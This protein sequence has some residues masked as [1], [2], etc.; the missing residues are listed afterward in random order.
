MSKKI[1]QK[2]SQSGFTLVET[3]MYIAFIGITVGMFVG[4]GYQMS[5]LRAKVSVI[6]NVEANGAMAIS[7]IEDYL[8]R[9]KQVS[10]PTPDSLVLTMFNDAVM[11]FSLTD[12]VLY[13]IDGVATSTQITGS[14]INIRNLTFVNTASAGQKD[15]IAINLDLEYRYH[16]SKAYEYNNVFQSLATL[17]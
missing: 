6:Q 8:K 16:G 9:A 3:I 14:A 2:N 17:R 13:L 10:V 7:L 4:F 5:D 11:T 12:G 1:Q 15:N